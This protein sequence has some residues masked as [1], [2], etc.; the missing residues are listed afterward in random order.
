MKLSVDEIRQICQKLGK[1]TYSPDEVKKYLEQLKTGVV[2][3]E[4]V[5]RATGAGQRL[6][7]LALYHKDDSVRD[8][9]RELRDKWK[10]GLRK[11]ADRVAKPKPMT[12]TASNASS[13]AASI[14][15]SRVAAVA[16][17]SVAG[18]TPSRPAATRPTKERS[19]DTDKVKYNLTGMPTRDACIKLMYNGLAA[20]SDERMCFAQSAAAYSCL[21]AKSVY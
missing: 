9:A 10:D 5:L 19:V 6:N 3:T 15:F 11:T 20:T 21:L 8:M 17:P 12:K 16:G 2:A 18:G 14:A 7:K 4:D 1:E 13:S